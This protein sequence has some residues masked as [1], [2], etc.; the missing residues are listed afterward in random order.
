MKNKTCCVASAIVTEDCY[1]EK[2][3]RLVHYR[4]KRAQLWTYAV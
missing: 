4:M 1:R 2:N 3:G